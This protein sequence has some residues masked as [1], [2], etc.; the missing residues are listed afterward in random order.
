MKRII[1]LSTI[2]LFLSSCN[3]EPTDVSTFQPPVINPSSIEVLGGLIGTITT[4]GSQPVEDASVHIK[5]HETTTDE[6]GNFS[7]ENV[8]LYQDGTFIEVSKPGYLLGSR[9]IYAIESEINVISLDLI[10]LDNELKILS[11]VNSVVEQEN[12][13]VNFPSGSY[14]LSANVNYEGEMS[15]HLATIDI[16]SNIDFNKMPGDLTGVN[17]AYETIALSSYK[18]FNVSLSSQSGENIQL[19]LN[20]NAIIEVGFDGEDLAS[21]P[22]VITMYYFDQNNGTWVERGEAILGTDGYSGEID[23]LGFWMLAASYPYA[24]IIGGLTSPDDMY[25]NTRL[26][27]YNNDAQYLN[28]INTTT[29]GNYSTRI[30][31]GVDLNLAIFHECAAG[32]QTEHLGILNQNR[33]ID[34]FDIETNMANIHIIGSVHDCD[35]DVHDGAHVKISFSDQQFLYRVDADGGFD[36]SFSNC[37]DSYLSVLAINDKTQ[38]VSDVL[39]VGIS[40]EINIG[41]MTTCN[42]VV[43]GYDISYDFMD[44]KDELD[45]SVDHSWKISSISGTTS[46]LIFSANMVDRF[47]GVN[48]LEAVFVITEGV[49]EA[50]YQLRFLTQAFNVFGSC[51]YELTDHDGFKSYRFFGIGDEIIST[52]DNIFPGGI[53][54]VNFSM[55]YYD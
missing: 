2:L 38:Q 48:Y 6:N 49:T 26:Q 1:L 25:K 23:D 44:W 42:E 12:L 11:S 55:V 53:D 41:D 15:V 37:S 47:T 54:S 21:L 28:A 16:E 8:S 29:A 4:N 39:D 36:Y 3:R 51:E 18:I 13:E 19:P 40:N 14:Q 20:S 52:D 7:F 5:G 9:K 33:I 24:E 31:Q 27:I 45:Q 32:N 46:R 10:A 34:N 22:S 43:A 17:K 50:D 35:G 30:P